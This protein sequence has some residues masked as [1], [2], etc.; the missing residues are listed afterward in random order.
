VE[1]FT[2]GAHNMRPQ[3][4]TI[5]L[6]VIHVNKNIPFLKHGLFFIEVQRGIR[7]NPTAQ[8]NRSPVL[9]F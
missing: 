4:D 1:S 5:R 2:V 9:L 7:Q 8:K 3:A 6:Y